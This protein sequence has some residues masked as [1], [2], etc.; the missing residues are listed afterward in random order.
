MRKLLTF[1]IALGAIVFAVVAPV[2]AT[3]RLLLAAPKPVVGCSQAT[4]F[5]AR[6][7][8]LS[9]TETT[10]YTNLICGLVSDGIITGTM[11]GANSGSGACGSLLDALYIFA[12]NNTTTANLN[13]C[14]TSYTLTP[15]NTP[16]F[17]AD[18]GYT[19]NASNMQ[20]STN[21]TPT[22]ATTP[23]YSQNSASMGAYVLNSRTTTQTYASIGAK[24]LS[25][26]FYSYVQNYRTSGANNVN[27][28]MNGTTFPFGTASPANAQGFTAVV[29]ASSTAISAYKNNNSTPFINAVADTSQGN[30]NV[31]ISILNANGLSSGFSADQI[32]AAFIGGGLTGA[33]W[34]AI[35]TRVNNYMTALGVNVY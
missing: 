32:S 12:T 35:S 27:V 18:N 11:N 4:T 31:S 16:T 20:L 26:T 24:Q 14:G 9:G 3:G 1:L 30:M 21:F 17:M 22:S 28:E 2:G 23:N 15:S 6:T 25:G 33:Q 8:G 29:R 13:L 7:T 5:L 19:G 34:L 10:A